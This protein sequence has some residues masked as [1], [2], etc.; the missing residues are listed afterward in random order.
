LYDIEVI[1]QPDPHDARQNVNP[2]IEAH[3][4]EP[5]RQSGP[6][7][8]PD[9]DDHGEYE[10]GQNRTFNGVERMHVSDPI[11]DY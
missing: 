1:E 9:A 7:A 8:E 5:D 3:R 10:A 4:M 6:E 11:V 2:S